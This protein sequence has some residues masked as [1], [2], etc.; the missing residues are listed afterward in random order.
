MLKLK[1]VWGQ[2]LDDKIK[3]FAIAKATTTTMATNCNQY[4]K[5]STNIKNEEKVGDN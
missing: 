1:Q 4:P 2:T 3:V 5:S